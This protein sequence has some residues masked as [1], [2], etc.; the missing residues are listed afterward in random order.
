MAKNEKFHEELEI[1]K[2]II[3]K[4]SL[5]ETIKWG[6]DVY[7]YQGKNVVG[8]V[9]FK[10]F[11]CLWFYNGVFLEDN[12]KVLF[13]AQ[14]GKTKA[15]RQ[16]RFSS[17]DEINEN[18]ILEYINEAIENERKG[19][20]WKAEKS[21]VPPIPA[22]LQTEF[23]KD[24]KLKSAFEKLSP[25]R[26]KEYIEHIDAAKKIETRKSRLEK[27]LPMI[28]GGRGLHDKYRK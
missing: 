12:N 20:I 6:T 16:W 9:G 13:N 26:Q 5:V 27:I 24:K 8:I 10:N 11:F 15:L 19:R 18:L 7:T 28:S 2:S 4:T 14:E 21:P 17:K 23:V 22:I 3:R 25:F 1:L